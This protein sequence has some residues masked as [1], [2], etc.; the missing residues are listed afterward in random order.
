MRPG[1]TY[2]THVP[3]MRRSA[4]VQVGGSSVPQGY[5]TPLTDTS[6]ELRLSNAP[7]RHVVDV[8]V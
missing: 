5:V 1:T 4:Q 3:F 8:A 2:L 7:V 6:F